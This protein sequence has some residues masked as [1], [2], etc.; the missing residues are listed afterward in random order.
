MLYQNFD[1]GLDVART[2]RE[3]EHNRASAHP[4]LSLG[5]KRLSSAGS[6]P[7]AVRGLS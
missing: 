4:A 1:S 7:P 5:L 6:W 2:R 3:V